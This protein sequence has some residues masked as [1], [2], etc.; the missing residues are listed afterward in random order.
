MNLRT[1]RYFVAIADAGSMTGAAEAISIAQPALSRQMHDLERDIGVQL[2]QRTPRG[3][4]LTAAGATLYESAQ[5][6]LGEAERVRA[7][8]ATPPA[9]TQSK[10]VLGASP[11]L[12]R[13]LV[14]AVFDHCHRSVGSTRLIVREAFTPVLLDM[15][16]KGL[17]DMAIITGLHADVGRPLSM[18]PLV[19]EPFALVTQKTRKLG[20]VVSVTELAEV[21]L[22]MTTLHRTIVE[23]ELQPLG[24]HLNIQSEF[25][26][27][28]AIR[29]L[30]LAGRWSTLM[31][32]SVFKRPR[33]GN[34]ITLSEV[35]G[36]QLNRQ[37]LMATRI[38]AHA[39]RPLAWLKEVVVA[40]LA[41]L[42]REGVFNFGSRGSAK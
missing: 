27:V 35:S 22:L 4:R 9:D 32:I 25:D 7:Q 37:L 12:S 8:L 16:E 15:L 14:P 30:V 17:I 1:L 40:E 10:V 11:T 5:R 6:M 29:E 36:V 39:N 2:L 19:G 33:S 18:H 41:R 23:R 3:V 34:K 13:V 38:E 28:D 42:T 21:P 31:P 24:I 26:S 20:P